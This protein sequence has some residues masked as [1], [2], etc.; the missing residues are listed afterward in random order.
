MGTGG[1]ERISVILLNMGGPD[2]LSAI[3]PFLFNLFRDSDIIKIPGGA[4]PQI[5]FA[6][7]LSGYRARKVKPFYEMIG[8]GS[9]LNRIS[10]V[11]AGMLERQLN[12]EGRELFTVHL[13]MRYWYPFTRDAVGEICEINPTRI[14]ALPL[15]PQYSRATT[16]SSFNDL[17]RHLSK[18]V[19][20]VGLTKVDHYFDHPG[21][22]DSIREILEG[23]LSDKREGNT[24]LIFSAHGLPK[25]MI[26]EGDP[27][28]SQVEATVGAIM[29]ALPDYSR[30]VSYKSR[31]GKRRLEPGTD[32]VIRGARGEGYDTVV[33]VPVSFVSD[34]METLYEMDILYREMAE[35]S[36]LAFKRS[37]SL[38]DSPTFIRA[39]GKITLAA[40]RPRKENSWPGK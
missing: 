11:Q 15:Y 17:E 23:T 26:E 34:H 31:A 13:G 35:D 4:I 6:Y 12:D 33:L 28:Q 2:T 30:I 24:L 9:P 5:L 19:P 20:D 25:S 21:Y 1:R 37:P 3:R 38:N 7:L 27:Y 22:I 16:G 40:L 39:L 18:A 32:E 29:D 36:G 8:G 10:M 14:I